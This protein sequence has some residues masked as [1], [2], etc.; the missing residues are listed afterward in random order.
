MRSGV[1]RVGREVSEQQ[2]RRGCWEKRRYDTRTAAR[3]SAARIAKRPNAP[4]LFMYRCTICHGFH[5]SSTRPVDYA[6]PLSGRDKPKNRLNN[7]GSP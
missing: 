7:Q 1:D 3:D 6:K 4:I 5:L 2:A